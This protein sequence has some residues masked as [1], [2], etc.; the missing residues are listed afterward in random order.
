LLV[1]VVI[2]NIPA[3]VCPICHEAYVSRD[4]AHQIDRLLGPFH[5]K[6]GRIPSLP[7]AEVTIDFAAAVSG[8]KAA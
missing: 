2:R 8:M 1:K 4:T 6:H 5:G 3:A 7:P